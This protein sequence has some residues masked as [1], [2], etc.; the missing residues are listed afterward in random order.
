MQPDHATETTTPDVAPHRIADDTW[1][2]PNLAHAGDDAF[3]MVNTMVITGEQPIIVDTGAP[4]HQ[5][6]WLDQV[7]S[8][9]EPDDVRWI[10]L[11]H[12]DG[13]HTGG[14][15]EALERCRNATL[16]AN[17][18]ITERLGLEK[19]LPLE[20]MVW[21]GPG[22]HLDAGDRRFHLVVPPIFDGPTTRA[23]FDERTG[24][25]WAADSFAA[26]TPGAVYER[27]DVPD[28]LFDEAFPLLNSLV[29][30]WHQWLDPI[31]YGRHVDTVQELGAQVV[32]S[33]HGP[34]L[35]GDDIADAFDRVRAMAGRPIVQP[36]GQALLDELVAALL[37][38]VA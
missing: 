34:V 8:I 1:L 21:L 15:H 18:F 36:P 20:R 32:A 9:V 26:F 31:A 13:D 16:V 29:S 33:A 28:D 30:P 3:L 19:P 10:Y 5:D 38:P 27:A 23:L 11:T 4:I 6:S 12:D 35:R 24:V 7:F 22:D 25:L 2:I 37:E 14:L 17:F